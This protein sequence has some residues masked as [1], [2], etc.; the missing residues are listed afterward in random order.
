MGEV[1]R[2]GHTAPR[3]RVIEPKKR[4]RSVRARCEAKPYKC[5]LLFQHC[6]IVRPS[7][8]SVSDEAGIEPRTVAMDASATRLDLISASWKKMDMGE[9]LT[10][11]C[12]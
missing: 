10:E 1:V 8:S 2:E 3:L 9:S 6:F 4:A 5:T 7:D 11:W 12:H